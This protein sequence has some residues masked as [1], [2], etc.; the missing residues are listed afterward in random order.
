MLLQMEKKLRVRQQLVCLIHPETRANGPVARQHTCNSDLETVP[1]PLVLTTNQ[2]HREMKKQRMLW[3]GNL[4]ITGKN[5]ECL[6]GKVLAISES[7]R[8]LH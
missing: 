1:L 6:N 7:V 4:Q 5:G 8:P 2:N 3:H